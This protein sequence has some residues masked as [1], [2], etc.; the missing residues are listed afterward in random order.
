MDHGTCFRTEQ[1]LFHKRRTLVRLILMNMRRYNIFSGQ[2]LGALV[3][4][5]LQWTVEHVLR[6]IEH[7]NVCCGP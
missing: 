4:E 3:M 1:A 6:A 2:S 5:H 7:V